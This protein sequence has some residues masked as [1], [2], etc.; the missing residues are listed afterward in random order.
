MNGQ[1][2]QEKFF[3][4]YGKLSFQRDLQIEDIQKLQNL[5][6]Q[7]KREIENLKDEVKP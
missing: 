3:Q 5:I 6:E 4:M 7:Q 1:I 2:D